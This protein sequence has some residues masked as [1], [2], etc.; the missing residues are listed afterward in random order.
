MFNS[1]RFNDDDDDDE[2]EEEDE[3]EETT[4]DVYKRM[5]IKTDQTEETGESIL[6]K[7]LER[8]NRWTADTE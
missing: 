8:R 7:R 6:R 1:D 3:E 5:Y 2:E 4:Q